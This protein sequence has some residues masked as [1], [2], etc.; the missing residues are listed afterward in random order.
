MEL[1]TKVFGFRSAF[2][3]QEVMRM[4]V[5]ARSGMSRRIGKRKGRRSLPLIVIILQ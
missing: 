4:P 5:M 1:M 2:C 3:P